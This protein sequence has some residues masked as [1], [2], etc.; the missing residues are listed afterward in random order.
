MFKMFLQACAVFTV[1]M[2]IARILGLISISWWI[3]TAPLWIIALVVF[4]SVILV[5]SLLPR[6]WLKASKPDKGILDGLS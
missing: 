3:I 4:F 1:I 2:F 5:L 6:G